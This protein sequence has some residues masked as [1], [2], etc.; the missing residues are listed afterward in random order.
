MINSFIHFQDSSLE[1][2]NIYSYDELTISP[3]HSVSFSDIRNTLKG[4][5]NIFVMIPSQLFGFMKYENKEGLKGE[6]LKANVLIEVEDQLISDVSSL[7]FFYNEELNLASWIDSS[8]FESIAKKFYEMDA[9][10]ILVPEHSLFQTG[11]NI[12]FLTENS[13][14]ISFSNGS[15]F[16][17][18]ISSL[19][20]Y[21]D[22]LE[23][24]S[25]DLNSLEAF[26]EN[27]NISHPIKNLIPVQKS[28]KEM[29]SGFTKHS[30]GS[31]FN[32]FKR[33]LSLQFLRSKFKLSYSE[34]WIMAAS[35]LIV[36]VAP[37]L[38][39][40]SLHSSIASYNE[41]TMTIFQ[42]LNPGFKKLVKPKKQ[43]DDLTKG[44]PL[45]SLVS[46]QDLEAL[47]YV[48]VLSD[49]SI[50][51]ININF[52]DREITTNVENLS[53]LKLSLFKELAN[54]KLIK[55]SDSGLNKGS[56]GWNGSLIIDYEND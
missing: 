20:D 33:K 22:R 6:I 15:G 54:S 38:I 9:E 29:H 21:L 55:I 41:N 44:V 24:N 32:L 25:F 36:L 40:H 45:Q 23:L 34:S 48:E 13:F 30:K 49:K 19:P 11:R 5:T 12:I 27:N 52:A 16:G 46:S 43:I 47:S 35:L 1:C 14:V 26:K 3:L 18:S 17:G 53:P 56:D 42:Q 10:I 39:N 50:R 37:L 2:I 31:S 28:W 51:S 8:I 4:S 7:K